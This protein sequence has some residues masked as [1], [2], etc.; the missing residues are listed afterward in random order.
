NGATD[1]PGRT[2][3]P[4]RAGLPART[5]DGA[6]PRRQFATSF[7]GGDVASGGAAR[8]RKGPLICAPEMVVIDSE[9]AAGEV[10]VLAG[11]PKNRAVSVRRRPCYQAGEPARGVGLVY[12]LS[13]QRQG[14]RRGAS[15]RWDREPLCFP[16]RS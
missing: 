10:G 9:G 8:A 14:N 13:R 15:P 16:R 4:G 11:T 1:R 7:A 12:S 3:R 5:R 6:V 2:G